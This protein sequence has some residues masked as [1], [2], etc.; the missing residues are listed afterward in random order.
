[1]YAWVY[2]VYYVAY[3]NHVYSDDHSIV[4]CYCPIKSRAPAVLLAVDMHACSSPYIASAELPCSV[5]SDSR[6]ISA[7][8]L[9]V[10]TSI[11]LYIRILPALPGPNNP[12][13]FIEYSSGHPAG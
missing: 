4:E 8:E 2:T 11:G 12:N 1:M 7:I 10:Y 13:I 3:S 5:E 6:I 9:L